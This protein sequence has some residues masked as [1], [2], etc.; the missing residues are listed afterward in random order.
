TR[1][2][3]TASTIHPPICRKCNRA[4]ATEHRILA[5]VRFRWLLAAL[6][7][8]LLAP[9]S[10]AAADD[11]GWVI[12]SFGADI[13]VR[14]DST[15]EIVETIKVDFRG[16][17]KHGIFRDI[18]VRYHHDQKRDRVYHLQVQGVG[19]GSGGSWPYE[20]SN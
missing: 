17:E 13:S 9:L 7:G 3:T 6:L 1:S 12:N 14:Q 18:P 10:V 8:L 19:N 20:V 5:M 11:T 15:L 16:L 4:P 2:T